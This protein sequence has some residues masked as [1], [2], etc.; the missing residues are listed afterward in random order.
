MTK[1]DCVPVHIALQLMDY[2]SLGRGN[3]YQ[4]FQ[5]T[6]RHLQKALKAIVNGQILLVDYNTL[7]FWLK[8]LRTPSGFQQLHRNVSQDTSQHPSIAK[9]CPVTEG[10]SSRCKIQSY[11]HQTRA[12]RIGLVFAEV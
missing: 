2:S 8:T 4:D 5:R 3:D 9:P 7:L 1:D 11:G 6:N 10:L 12:E